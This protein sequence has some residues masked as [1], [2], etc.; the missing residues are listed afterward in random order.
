MICNGEIIGEE[1]NAY[2]GR[3]DNYMSQSGQSIY[4]TDHQ[5]LVIERRFEG[6]ESIEDI[7]K[8]YVAEQFKNRTRLDAVGKSRYNGSCDKVAVAFTKEDRK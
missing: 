8:D 5:I 1:A 3:G 4:C 6:N 7:I 2:T